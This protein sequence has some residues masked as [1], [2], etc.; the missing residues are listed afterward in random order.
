M[1]DQQ[2]RALYEEGS[3][4]VVPHDGM[5][6]TI[7]QRLTQST[8]TIPHFYLT[9]DCNIGKLLAK[10]IEKIN[11]LI[12]KKQGVTMVLYRWDHDMSPGFHLMGPQ[13]IAEETGAEQEHERRDRGRIAG[14]RGDGHRG[15]AGI[16]GHRRADRLRR[17]RRVGGGDRK[18]T[19]LNSS[20]RT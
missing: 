16:P 5:R 6:R 10:A 2:I 11:S 13:G 18:S 15:L 8:Q 12:G 20:H 7:A 9:I 1:S 19:R 17:P 4:E 3:Y 14:V